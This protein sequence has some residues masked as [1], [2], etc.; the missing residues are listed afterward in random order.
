MSLFFTSDLHLHDPRT[1]LSRGYPDFRDHDKRIAANWIDQVTADDDVWVLGDLTDNRPNHALDIVRQL[2]GRKH[3]VLG[4]HDAGHPMFLNSHTW[5]PY[6]LDVFD[7]VVPMAHIRVANIDV[8]LS[9]FPYPR[10]DL[11]DVS[12]EQWRL[13]DCGSWLFHGHVHKEGKRSAMKSINVTVDAWGFRL[14]RAGDLNA[15]TLGSAPTPAQERQATPTETFR[16][17]TAINHKAELVRHRDRVRCPKCKA[18]ESSLSGYEFPTILRGGA[19]FY[20]C[21]S[22]GMC[23]HTWPAGPIADQAEAKMSLVA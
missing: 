13:P 20:L 23:F 14:M 9:H 21:Q 7:T 10:P 6:Y 8:L 11:G 17:V 12:Y 4:N 18:N 2:P 15:S 19:L 16:K 1:A 22:C 5:L 3:L